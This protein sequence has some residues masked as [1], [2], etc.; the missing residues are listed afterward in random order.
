M[1]TPNVRDGLYLR[2]A[3][4]PHADRL[5]AE[6]WLR[7]RIRYALV[8][9]ERSFLVS[10]PLAEVLLRAAASATRSE[11]ARA[12]ADQ[13]LEAAIERGCQWLREHGMRDFRTPPNGPRAA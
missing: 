13:R 2:H 8:R 1:S 5:L 6:R 12:A 11:Q 4:Q 7:R 9:G 3:R 10:V